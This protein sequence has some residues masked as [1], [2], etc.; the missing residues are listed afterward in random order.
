LHLLLVEIEDVFS[1]IAV[2]AIRFGRAGKDDRNA[3]A[4]PITSAGQRSPL[5]RLGMTRL[6]H[7]CSETIRNRGHSAVDRNS[8][9][10]VENDRDPVLVN[11]HLRRT[12]SGLIAMFFPVPLSITAELWAKVGNGV[13]RRGGVSWGCS[14][15]RFPLKEDLPLKED[16]P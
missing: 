13:M 1:P 4:V 9:I 2:E 15:L 7:S 5:G 8:Q 12:S 16:T 11:F 6:P 3:S 10:I 14:S